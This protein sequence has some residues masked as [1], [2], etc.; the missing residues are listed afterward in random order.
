M[1][2]T[3][4]WPSSAQQVGCL[5]IILPL[6]GFNY[7]Q[8]ISTPLP[9]CFICNTKLHFTHAMTML[10][11]IEAG[12]CTEVQSPVPLLSSNQASTPCVVSGFLL[13]KVYAL[14]ACSPCTWKCVPLVDLLNGLLWARMKWPATY[15]QYFPPQKQEY[16]L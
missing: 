3:V 6:H 5:C 10:I 9:Q 11:I 13:V 2:T 8:P 15:T 16:R 7:H 1:H 4:A 12:L 14:A